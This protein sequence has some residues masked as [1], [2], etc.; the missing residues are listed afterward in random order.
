MTDNATWYIEA[1][2]DDIA[3]QLELLSAVPKAFTR[4]QKSSLL[5][6]ASWRIVQ[7]LQV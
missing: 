4:A 5:H 1:S 6:E 2:D 7:R 3:E